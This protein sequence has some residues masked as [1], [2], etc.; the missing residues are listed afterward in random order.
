M[1]A[2]AEISEVAGRISEAEFNALL[3]LLGEPERRWFFTGRGRSGLVAAM[4]AMRF[5]H[6]GRESYLVG[7]PTTPA[8]R[9]DDGLLVVSGSGATQTSLRHAATARGEGAR[10]A[11]LTHAVGSPLAEVSDVVLH[12]PAFAS[13]QFGRNL[14]DHTALV[15]L[16]SLVNTLACSLDDP[17][18]VLHRQHANLL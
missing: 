17:G 15:L 10:I 3:A 1:A 5:M 11:G 9:A 6:I 18:A 4:V 2:L 14:F 13:R 7:E 12:V 16:D 8:I